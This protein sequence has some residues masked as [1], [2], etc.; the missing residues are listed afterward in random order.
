M[1]ENIKEKK[2]KGV[3]R[4]NLEAIIFALV[5]ALIIKGICCSGIQNPFRFNA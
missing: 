5:L 2:K 3:L 1:N 4:E